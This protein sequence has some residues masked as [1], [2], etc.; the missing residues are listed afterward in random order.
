MTAL[1]RMRE[2]AESA[3][4]AHDMMML[5]REGIGALTRAERDALEDLE[6]F[7][8]TFN[9][10]SAAVLALIA[11]AE[12]AAEIA[13]DDYLEQPG[14]YATGI[15]REE[16]VALTEAVHRLMEVDA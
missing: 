4:A 9:P 13:S 8:I 2:I 3:A 14:P 5:K 15:R 12:T 10:D 6:D 7:D 16:A 1:D 11:V